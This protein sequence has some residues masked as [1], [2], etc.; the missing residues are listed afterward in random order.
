MTSPAAPEPAVQ[1]GDDPRK[2]AEILTA[3]YDAT[4]AGDRSP[5]RPRT[6]IGESWERLMSQGI[7]PDQ[8]PDTGTGMTPG[9]LEMHRHESGLSDV[10]DD[11]ARG[12][13][14]VITDGDNI[15]V[16]A[17]RSGRVLWRSGSTQV[18]SKADRL[19]FV[20]GANWAENSVGTNAIGTALVSR[21]AVQIFSAEHYVRSH[22]PWTCAGAPIHDPRT[23]DVI[24]AVDVSGPAATI[25][26]TTVALVDVVA[27]LAE[28]HLRELHRRTLD[29]LRSVA[30]P[31]LARMTGPAMAV[32]GHG[33]VAA[34]DSLAP[35]TRVLL[36]ETAA[37]G[38]MWVPALGACDLEPLPGGWLVRVFDDATDPQ[39]AVT[40][41]IDV[42]LRDPMRPM[43]QVAGR[44]GA[45]THEPTPRH[46]EILYLLAIHRSGRT[47][48][49][50]AEA[51]FGDDGKAIT[52]RAEMS[53]L[54]RQL[55]GIVLGN[56]YRY[57]ED[58]EVELLLPVDRARL[59]PQSCAPAIRRARIA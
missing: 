28:S 10:M 1:P 55:A 39:D 37:S 15:P 57:P 33:W 12:L 2:Y 9:D 46:A 7:S 4:M 32:D 35:H 31:M 30:A 25:H 20:E 14:T 48:P 18:L 52:V 54:R 58:A 8:Q 50:M 19:G 24:G 6:V 23:G 13:D 40:T 21:K 11:L 27:K 51:L 17:D 29:R 16:V 41:R 5:A 47:A 43:L 45:W 56:P 42:D 22:H 53:R 36:P 44:A 34:V 3:V 26:P 38:R 49:Q 59:L